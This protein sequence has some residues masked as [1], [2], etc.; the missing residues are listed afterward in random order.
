[1]ADAGT[2]RTVMAIKSTAAFEK[3][4]EEL[5]QSGQS[6]CRLLVEFVEDILDDETAEAGLIQSSM[7]EFM[8]A[9]KALHDLAEA[10]KL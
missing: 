8:D 4:L 10:E 9:A 3:K 2:E 1:M 6:E 7:Q 5:R